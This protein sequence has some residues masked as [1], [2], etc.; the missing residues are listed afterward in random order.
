MK[1]S[2]QNTIMWITLIFMVLM[3]GIGWVLKVTNTSASQNNTMIFDRLTEHERILINLVEEKGK[4]RM[5]LIFFNSNL[6]RIENKIDSLNNKMEA[7]N[8]KELQ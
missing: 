6:R 3:A 8:E 7:Q 4:T 5:E 1:P 2:R